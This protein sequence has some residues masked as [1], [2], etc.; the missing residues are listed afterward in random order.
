[1]GYAARSENVFKLLTGK[2]HEIFLLLLP[3]FFP[4]PRRRA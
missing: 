1:M 3:N 4:P 2:P